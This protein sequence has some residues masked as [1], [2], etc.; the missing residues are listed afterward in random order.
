MRADQIALQL[1]TIR[2]AC[3][4]DLTGTLRAVAA[5]GYTA[6]E[7]AGLY[8]RTAE[9]MRATLD[10]L[11]LRAVSAHVGHD[12]FAADPGRVAADLQTL[13]ASFAVLPSVPA[14]RRGS[15]AEARA[16][17]A[18][19]NRW[20]AAIRATGLRFAY[21]H[22]A[23]EFEP[24][25]SSTLWELI[26]SETDPALVALELDVYWAQAGGH[27]PA[28]LIARHA[29]RVAMLHLKDLDPAGGRDAP[30]GEGTL[31]W[32][33]ILAA[34]RAAGAAWYIIEQDTPRD[35]LRDVRVAREQMLLRALPS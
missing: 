26:V 35:A 21:H 10:E 34:G 33:A 25:E 31:D 16:L 2:E 32:E 28:A 20:G 3:A 24:L 1:Y 23:F 30:A 18:D 7:T 9:A 13:G 8:G 5:M 12:L 4:R 14:A 17:V 27:D 11:G 22:H 6:V 19:L 15:L 29:D